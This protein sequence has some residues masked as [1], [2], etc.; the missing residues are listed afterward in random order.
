MKENI[1]RPKTLSEISFLVLLVANNF[2]ALYFLAILF[3]GEI[4]PPYNKHYSALDI[5]ARIFLYGF[6]VSLFFSL[7]SLAISYL[8]KLYF[9]QALNGLLKF[10]LLQFAFLL[11]LF[12]TAAFF[13]FILPGLKF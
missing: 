7:I 2:T 11:I 8:F 6:I 12:V 3:L 13:V 1:S 5:Y 4:M 9:E 10:F